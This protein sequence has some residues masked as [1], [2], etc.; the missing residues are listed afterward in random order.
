MKACE[1]VEDNKRKR[2]MPGSSG[3][4]SSGALPMYYMV[5][6]PLAGQQRRTL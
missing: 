5:Y 1:A 6:T 4:S 2:S 3:G